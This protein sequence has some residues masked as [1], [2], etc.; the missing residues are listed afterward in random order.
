MFVSY[1]PHSAI[2]HASH[3]RAILAQLRGRQLVA[4]LTARCLAEDFLD[5]FHLV[6]N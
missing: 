4:D 3:R 1:Q 5:F 6:F 2:A